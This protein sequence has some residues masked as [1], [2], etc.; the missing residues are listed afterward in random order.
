MLAF[1]PFPLWPRVPVTLHMWVSESTE[2]KPFLGVVLP[3]TK[4]L[5][6]QLEDQRYVSPCLA[7]RSGLWNFLHSSWEGPGR[8]QM[9]WSSWHQWWL[10]TRTDSLFCEP[11]KLVQILLVPTL[12]SLLLTYFKKLLNFSSMFSSETTVF[13]LEYSCY[14]R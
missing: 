8:S 4:Q 2:Y 12:R 11:F 6:V 14:I 7:P 1:Q 9:V 3:F 5:M 13:V 10:P